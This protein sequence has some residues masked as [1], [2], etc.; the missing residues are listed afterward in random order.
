MPFAH[1]L[2]ENSEHYLLLDAQRQMAAKYGR[3]LPAG[4]HTWR[5][6]FWLSVF[7][8][9]YR[10]LPWKV[11]R[12]TIQTMPGSHRRQWTQ[13]ARRG[14]PAV[15]PDGRVQVMSHHNPDP[16]GE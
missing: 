13:P 9:T 2:R 14:T 10:R 6:R 15:G 3:P 1:W 11:R 8:P 7:A 4:P 12:L 16:G 5:D